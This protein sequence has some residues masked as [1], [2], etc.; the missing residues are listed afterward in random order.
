[1]CRRVESVDELTPL[2]EE[3]SVIAIG[4]GLGQAGWGRALFARVLGIESAAGG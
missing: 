4:P 1:M 2:M 3:A